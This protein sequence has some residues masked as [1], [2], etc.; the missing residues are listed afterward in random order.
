M[1]LVCKR[2]ISYEEFEKVLKRLPEPSMA[3]V[4]LFG[5][6]Y[7]DSVRRAGEIIPGLDLASGSP[8]FSLR[9]PTKETLLNV[10]RQAPAIEDFHSK[11]DPRILFEYADWSLDDNARVRINRQGI[12]VTYTTKEPKCVSGIKRVLEGTDVTLHILKD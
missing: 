10:Y 5:F 2:E 9:H 12:T 8:I 1:S 6:D 3:T 11:K 7:S 4:Q